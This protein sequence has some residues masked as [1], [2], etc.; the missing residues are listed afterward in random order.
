VPADGL[1]CLRWLPGNR[2][3]EDKVE[4]KE[5]EKENE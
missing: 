2:K 1:L 5:K 4:K 3:E